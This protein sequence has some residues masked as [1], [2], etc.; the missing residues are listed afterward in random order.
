MKTR[1][2]ELLTLLDYRRNSR[3][4]NESVEHLWCQYKTV[5][6]PYIKKE[7]TEME[8]QINEIRMRIDNDHLNTVAKEIE[9]HCQW[10]NEQ[11]NFLMNQIP[12]VNN[13]VELKDEIITIANIMQMYIKKLQPDPADPDKT[14]GSNV[15]YRKFYKKFVKTLLPFIRKSLNQIIEKID[16]LK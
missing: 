14:A 9:Q 16:A 11:R 8:P 2:Y 1:Y 6:E 15:G 10:L 12:A 13:N 5:H 7:Y 3:F 4:V